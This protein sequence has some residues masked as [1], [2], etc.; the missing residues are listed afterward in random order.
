MSELQQ[1]GS[2]SKVRRGASPRPIDDPK[3]FGGTVGWVRISDVTA[4]KKY[5]RA[6]SQ[7]LSKLGEQASVRVDKGDLVMSICGTIGKPVLI[8]MPA[9][10]HDG[11]VQI[12]DFVGADPEYL[13]Y[14]LQLHAQRLTGMGQSGTQTNINTSIV[15]RLE[16]FLPKLPNQRRIAAILSALDEQI[17]KTEALIDKKRKLKN[18]MVRQQLEEAIKLWGVCHVADLCKVDPEILGAETPSNYQFQYIDISSV[19]PNKL[20]NDLS[21]FEFKDAP[22]RARKKVARD[23]VLMATVRPNLQAFAKVERDGEL[24]ASTGFAVLRAIPDVSWP[25]FIKQVIFYEDVTKQINGL[26]AGSN[27]PAITVGNVKRLLIPAPP[28]REQRRIADLLG[29]IDDEHTSEVRMA[30]KLRSQKVGL[31]QDLLTGKV[32]VSC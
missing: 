22:S 26:V 14:Q 29:A 2:F 4:S 8:D 5:L 16:V 11:F 28:Y 27:Y 24:V 3:Y 19:E 25:E 18:G 23:D 6:T 10:I 32:R 1:I 7:Y 20:G 13:Y 17:E 12:Y 9:C 15:E 31:M 21:T 30:Y